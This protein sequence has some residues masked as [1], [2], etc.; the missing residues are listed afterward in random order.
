M[1][2]RLSDPHVKEPRG[3]FFGEFVQPR[4]LAHGGRNGD[5]PLIIRGHNDLRE[6]FCLLTLGDDVLNEGPTGDE[7]QRFAGKARGSK[8]RRD[9]ANGFH[10]GRLSHRY[11]GN[12]KPNQS[13]TPG[14]GS[15]STTDGH[16]WGSWLD[17]R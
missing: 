9:D 2:V 1:L 16:G 13:G 7:R 3:E 8:A 17:A 12:R 15:F 6:R 14:R 11:P 5:N 4:A 10:G